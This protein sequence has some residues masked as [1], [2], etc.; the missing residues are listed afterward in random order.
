MLRKQCI[1]VTE[2]AELATRIDERLVLFSRGKL[3]RVNPRSARG[4]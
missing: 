1:E 3:C 2:T 4:M